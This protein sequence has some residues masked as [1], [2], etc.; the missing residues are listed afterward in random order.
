MCVDPWN[1]L[2]GSTGGSVVRFGADWGQGVLDLFTNYSYAMTE[3]VN[4]ANDFGTS[5][6]KRRPKSRS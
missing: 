1:N 3:F 5:S 4:I 6:A 2:Y